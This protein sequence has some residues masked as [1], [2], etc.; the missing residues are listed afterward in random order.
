MNLRDLPAEL[1]SEGRVAERRRRI[2]DELGVNLSLLATE[3]ER[4]GSA[5]EKNCEQ[6]FGTIPLPVGYAGPLPVKFSDGESA[7]IHLPLATTE[8]ALVASVNRGCKALSESGGVKVTSIYHGISRSIAWRAISDERSAMSKNS[9]LKAHSSKLI[10]FL[11]E[12]KNDWKQIGEGTSLHLKIL[13]HTIDESG[14][15]VFL[16]INADTSEAMGMNM[17]TIAAQA[18]GEFIAE[19]CDCELVTIAANVDSDKKPSKRTHDEGRGYEVIAEATIPSS[20][21]ETVLKT[22]PEKML[23]VADA[24][25]THGSKLAGAIG[26]NLHAANV[27]AALYLA[28]GQDAAHVVEGSLCD[29]TMKAAK[30]GVYIHVRLPAIL[31]GVRGGGTGLPAQ[32]QCLNLLM[33]SCMYPKGLAESIGAAVLA[34]ELSLL[35]AQ[36]NQELATSH[37]K[38]ARGK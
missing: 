18:I 16:T 26:S 7:D 28:T 4:I 31:V 34:G 6:M 37:K 27:I 19:Q 3:P 9:N 30:D 8:G 1:T 15:Y 35:A 29:T 20:V 22:T 11:Q 10:A 5:E 38:L 32:A 12:K 14:D 24:K 36:A 21:I 13:S 33:Q 2:Q 23:A 25:L 17:V